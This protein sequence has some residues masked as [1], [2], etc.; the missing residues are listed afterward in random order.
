MNS[1]LPEMRSRP[2]AVRLFWFA[3]FVLVASAQ[4]QSAS[5]LELKVWQRSTSQQKQTM[6]RIEK[7][8]PGSTFVELS[9][10]QTQIKVTLDLQQMSSGPDGSTRWK[11]VIRELQFVEDS[12][13]LTTPSDPVE[14]RRQEQTQKALVEKNTAMVLAGLR[15]A[16]L[17]IAQTK[18]GQIS[19]VAVAGLVQK[20]GAALLGVKA[21]ERNEARSQ[22]APLLQ[23]Q[24]WQTL[25]SA[26]CP[27][28]PPTRSLGD[29]W[30][31]T[32]D[33]LPLLKLKSKGGFSVLQ[34]SKGEGG[35]ARFNV[36][37]TAQI[38]FAQ[39]PLLQPDSA[40]Y[41]LDY[42]STITAQTRFGAA[43]SW[44]LEH[45]SVERGKAMWRIFGVDKKGRASLLDST[46]SDFQNEAR[47]ICRPMPIGVP[48]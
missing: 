12:P 1:S 35:A 39:K 48:R 4:G 44:P 23:A 20:A 6:R 13:P 26:Q 19:G 3:L 7:M 43:L 45:F 38:D 33:V 29:K 11:A 9:R 22:L 17:E 18:D 8:R 36:S 27:R 46:P 15:G 34:S 25:L 31:Y 21:S 10:T 40:E 16:N 14:M 2:L 5:H 32:P 24:T 28:Q 41:V 30:S 37:S 47:L 42:H